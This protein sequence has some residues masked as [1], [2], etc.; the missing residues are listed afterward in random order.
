MIE[1]NNLFP[2]PTLYLITEIPIQSKIPHKLIKKLLGK[3]IA[4][5]KIITIKNVPVTSRD[6]HI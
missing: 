3:K 4:K 5:N 1:K 2:E 6:K